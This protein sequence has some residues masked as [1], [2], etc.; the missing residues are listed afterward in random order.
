M[1]RFYI[2]SGD[3]I[4]IESVEYEEQIRKQR[5]KL[6]HISGNEYYRCVHKRNDNVG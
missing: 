4:E 2:D 5:K 3:E 6:N 1:I